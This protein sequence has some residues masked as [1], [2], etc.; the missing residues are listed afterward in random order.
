MLVLNLL[1]KSDYMN[2]GLSSFLKNWSHNLQ[3][4]KINTPAKIAS[5]I[6]RYLRA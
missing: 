5:S 4:V 6:F 2:F 3:E 1:L